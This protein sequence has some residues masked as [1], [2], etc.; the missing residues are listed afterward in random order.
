M[1]CCRKRRGEERR[2]EERRGEERRSAK[3]T[4]SDEMRRDT[5][6][7]HFASH[8]LRPITNRDGLY[9]TT[10]ELIGRG[11][12]ASRFASY[13]VDVPSHSRFGREGFVRA[14]WRCQGLVGETNDSQTRGVTLEHSTKLTLLANTDF[15]GTVPSA[16]VTRE[17]V[18]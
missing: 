15:G 6:D 14:N 17:L 4:E 5:R 7:Q 18:E 10:Y 1:V 12:D 13:S 3:E 2:G 9:F 16:F 11:T 8:N